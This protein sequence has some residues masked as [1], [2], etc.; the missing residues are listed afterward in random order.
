MHLREHLVIVMVGLLLDEVEEE[1]R[2]PSVRPGQMILD[3]C[4]P[5]FVVCDRRVELRQG[6][7][8]LV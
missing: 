5:F 1:D 7:M 6:F 2:P 3:V 4:P 8:V